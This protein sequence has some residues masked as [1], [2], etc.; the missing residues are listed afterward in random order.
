MIMRQRGFCTEIS[1]AEVR[2]RIFFAQPSMSPVD[3]PGLLFLHN[4]SGVLID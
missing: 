3:R 2:G 1:S 4:Q